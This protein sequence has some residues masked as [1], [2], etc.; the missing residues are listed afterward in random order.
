MN[1]AYKFVRDILFVTEISAATATWVRVSLRKEP[2]ARR[3]V[4]CVPSGCRDPSRSSVSKAWQSRRP[5]DRRIFFCRC[6]TKSRRCAGGVVTSI[7][8]QWTNTFHFLLM[9]ISRSA[10]DDG[11]CECTPPALNQTD[12]M[13]ATRTTALHACLKSGTFCNCFFSISRSMR[14]HIHVPPIAH[15]RRYA[16]GR[17]RCCH[18]PLPQTDNGREYGMSVS[19]KFQFSAS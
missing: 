18:L 10:K 15:R 5:P 13:Q 6:C 2:G 12:E 11:M 16:S 19:G 17:L 9:D 1:T 14:V 3:Q 8:K 7:Q 4:R